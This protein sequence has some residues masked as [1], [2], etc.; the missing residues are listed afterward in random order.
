[1]IR[2][3]TVYRALT[4]L[5][6]TAIANTGLAQSG[7]DVAARNYSEY[8]QGPLSADRKARFEKDLQN[9]EQALAAGDLAKANNASSA[10]QIISFRG[11]SDRHHAVSVKCMG[12]DTAQ[13][14]HNASLEL[15]RQRAAQPI[16]AEYHVERPPYLIAADS[17]SK[18]LIEEIKSREAAQFTGGIRNLQ[19]IVE[20]LEWQRS[21]G[22][23]ILADEEA[24]ISACNTALGP[25]IKQANENMQ[26][27]LV[28]ENKAFNQQLSKDE[29]N[30]INNTGAIAQAMTGV[31]MDSG[32]EEEAYVMNRRVA[33]SMDQ[34]R[35]A[36]AWDL[37]GYANKQLGSV[38]D[39]ARTRGDT[40]Q[41]KANDTS[42]LFTTRDQFYEDAIRY[43]E[44]G[45]WRQQA[46]T[47][48]SARG[49]IQKDL[50]AEE[51]R[52]EATNEKAR[53]ELEVKAEA[54]RQTQQSMQ[55]TEAEKQS[56]KDEADAL[57]AEL[58]F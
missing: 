13:R 25:L 19:N 51:A 34:L 5:L 41:N 2:S 27:A 37:A 36:R 57:E 43:Y 21:F 3:L 56:F 54:M 8:C 22:A 4:A 42:L 46:T 47:A 58:G 14:W 10:A 30:L 33:G 1:M 26:A 52:R 18:G 24:I 28:A 16:G 17:G 45:D 48:K 11:D 15:D 7:G 55:K 12:R 20:E 23:Y 31:K 44:F 38:A 32:G 40:M 53:Q 35:E 29:L 39:R 50:Q 9:I 6:I 49:A